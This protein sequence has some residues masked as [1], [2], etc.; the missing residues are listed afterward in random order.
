MEPQSAQKRARE[1]WHGAVDWFNS[2]ELSENAILIVFS[3]VIGVLSALGVAAFYKS[4][5]LAFW[6]FY[7]L[8]GELIPRLAL[9]AYRPVLTAAGFAVA[10][11]FMRYIGR[12]HDG[13]N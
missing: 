12:G 8:A 13:M 6:L 5:D 10:W 4:I 1:T 2:L 11:W 7:K 3:L 9:F